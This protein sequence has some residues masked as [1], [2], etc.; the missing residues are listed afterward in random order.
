MRWAVTLGVLVAVAVG[1]WLAV[2]QVRTWLDAH[3]WSWRIAGQWE[4]VK[5]VD[6]LTTG[7]AV[8]F[9]ALGFAAGIWF[10]ALVGW[11][12]ARLVGRWA[13]REDYS[14]HHQ[15]LADQQA[16]LGRQQ[17][18][19]EESYKR[20]MAEVSQREAAALQREREAADAKARAEEEIAKAHRAAEWAERRRKAAARRKDNASAAGRRLRAKAANRK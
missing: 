7:P 14:R 9:L 4:T 3:A 20:G 16:K 1:G 11:P 12:Y 13:A 18:Q 10:A 19:Q 5:G 2:D 6:L 8:P 17:Q 15:R